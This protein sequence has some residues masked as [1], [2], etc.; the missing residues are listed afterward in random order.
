MKIAKAGTCGTKA[1]RPSGKMKN[2]GK[3][4]R[5]F[6][7]GTNGWFATKTGNTVCAAMEFRDRLIVL[8]AGDGFQ[9]IPSLLNRLHLKRA[10]VFLSHLHID[11]SAGL[12]ILPLLSRGIRIRIFAHKSYLS[13]LRRLLS[14]PY[15]ASAEEQW[16]KVTLHPLCTGENRLPYSVRVLPLDHADPCF[17]FRF[18]LD[19]KEVAYCTDTGPCKIISLLARGSDALITECALLPGSKP[20]TEWP[21]LSPEMAAKEAVSAGAHL[22]LL[23]H[24]DAHKYPSLSLRMRAQEA[25]QKIFPRTIAAKDGMEMEI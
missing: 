15:T 1:G 6:F 25:A 11:H 18:S 4:I 14:H 17:G 7:L 24:F 16:A 10:D 22:L 8:D 5:V 19:G 20:M 21:H 23:T 12:H 9:H 2:Q 13:A 3:K